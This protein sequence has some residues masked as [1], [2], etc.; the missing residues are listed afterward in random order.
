MIPIYHS[1]RTVIHPD[2]QGFGLGLKLINATSKFMK[3]N[4]K[5]RIMAK[6]SSLPIYKSMSKNSDWKLLKVLRTNGK[7]KTGG[8][9]GR[10]RGHKAGKFGVGGFREGGVRTFSFEYFGK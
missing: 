6:F 1:N 5:Y 8:N 7:M 2:Y 9:Y 4:Y 3:E 10:N